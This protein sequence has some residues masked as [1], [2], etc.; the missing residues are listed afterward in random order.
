MPGNVLRI[1]D[2]VLKKIEISAIMGHN[3]QEP[4]KKYME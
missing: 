2:R 1:E 3:K 4:K